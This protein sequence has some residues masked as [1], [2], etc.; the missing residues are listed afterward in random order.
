MTD[1]NLIKVVDTEREKAV[2]VRTLTL[3]PLLGE[4]GGA[5]GAWSSP[6]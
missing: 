4:G 1:K 2:G 5:G 6:G 3:N